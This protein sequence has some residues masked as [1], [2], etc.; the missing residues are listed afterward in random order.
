MTEQDRDRK[1]FHPDSKVK[2]VVP[3]ESQKHK[4]TFK[5]NN[6]ICGEVFKS[7]HLLWKHK[8]VLG[9]KKNR[10]EIA[11]NRD[12][13]EKETATKQ[14][15]EKEIAKK[16][17]GQKIITNWVNTQTDK[18]E[19]TEEEAG[20]HDSGEIEEDMEVDDGDCNARPRKINNLISKSKQHVDWI[21]CRLC[22]K[23]FHNCCVSVEE[24][25]AHLFQCDSH[26]E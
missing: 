6:V 13:L 25:N 10:S 9:H 14:S 1:L 21:Q 3:E 15:K 23:W 20:G 19:D 7:H 11:K 18:D 17:A 26:K 8:T 12:V 24:E 16:I 5:I 2:D 4:C 22:P